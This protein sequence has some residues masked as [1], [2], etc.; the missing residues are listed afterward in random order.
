MN[1]IIVESPTKAKAL[2]GFLGRKYRVMATMGHIRDLPPK[3]LGVDVEHDFRPTY[4]YRRG[5]KKA[6]KRLRAA[7]EKASTIYLAMDPDREGEAI[8]WHVAEVIGPALEGKGVRRVTFHEITRG[9]VKAAVARPG[10][11]DMDLVDAQQARRILD[12]LVGYQVSPVLW[13]AIRG[14]KGL[15]AGRV[16]TVALRLVVERDRRIEEFDP[17]EYWLLEVELSKLVERGRR[18]RARLVE[19][20]GEKAD[21]ET[22]AEAQAIVERIEAADYR[23]LDVR[24]KRERRRPYPPYITS[25]LQRDAARKLH[26][27]ASKTMRVAQQLYE[28]INLPD[29]GVTGLITYMRTDSTQVAESAQRE[30]RE[31]IARYWGEDYLPDSPPRYE[32]RSKV[33]QEAHEAIRP[34]SSE[35]TPKSMREHLTPDQAKLYEWIWRRFV[36]SQ[37]R[38]AVYDDA[39]VDVACARG[40]NDLP[41]LFRAS[42]RELLFEG[43][44]KVYPA[45]WSQRSSRKLGAANQDLPSLMV[46][47]LLLL[48]DAIS[49]Q[50]FT[51]PPPHFT[52]S[53]LIKELEKRGI[54]RP[55][56]YAG[57]VSTLFRRK[58]VERRGRSLLA[59]PLGFVVCDFLVKQFPDVFAVSFTAEMEEELDCIARGKRGRVA[60]LRSFYGPFAAA[61]EGAR[62]AARNEAITAPKQKAEAKPT[63]E[64]CPQCGGKVVLRNG[65]YGQFRGCSNFPR[66]KW[67]APSK[68]KKRRVAQ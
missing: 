57:I 22:E 31:V 39:T 67:T 52:E 45:R 46:E 17:E 27:G 47:E 34:T 64:R 8:A 28:G 12:R 9:A 24:R 35:R 11:L 21:L 54:G 29:E 59:T 26:W 7:A 56:T 61:V 5:G 4:W 2:R 23:V 51:E 42:G 60:V 43:F 44:M 68:S 58:Y 63:G 40:G 36:A 10:R 62:A 49:E 48:H 14:R 25:T 19:I 13:K 41:Y 16:Q 33:A 1:L 37:M 38:P 18:F 30:V 20:G 3:Q 15:S 66:C 32:T 50:H 53:S 65:K 6:A 55:S